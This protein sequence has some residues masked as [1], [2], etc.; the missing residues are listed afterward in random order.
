MNVPYLFY[1]TAH[2]I[3][4]DLLHTLWLSFLFFKKNNDFVQDY[5]APPCN[6]APQREIIPLGA[7]GVALLDEKRRQFF[8]PLIGS[9][10]ACG[11]YE[12]IRCEK[13]S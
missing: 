11:H 6:H 8:S 9:E 5:T 10:M 7:P 1:Q 2:I 12:P 3:H 4:L 13:K